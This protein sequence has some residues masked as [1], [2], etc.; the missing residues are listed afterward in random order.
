LRKHLV[1]GQGTLFADALSGSKFFDDSFRELV[2]T[3]FPREKLVDIPFT[4]TLYTEAYDLKDVVYSGGLVKEIKE[5]KTEGQVKEMKGKTEGFPLLEGVK[6]NGRWAIIY[7]KYDLSCALQKSLR[8]IYPGYKHE[9]A[10]R[11]TTNI[12][13]YS[14]L[15]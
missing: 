4:D 3:I 6:I 14:V 12:V 8:D 1:E 13:I 15:P 7:S 5:D 9:S 11:I 2:T 10:I